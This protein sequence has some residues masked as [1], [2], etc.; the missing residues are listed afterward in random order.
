[1]HCPR[2]GQQQVSD[3]IK[4]CSRCGFQLG[5]VAELLAHG[6]FLPQLTELYKGKTG[7]FTRKNGVIAAILWFIF[8]VMM[9]PAF[10]AVADA[11]VPAAISA[12]FGVFSSLIML[13]ASIAFLPSSKRTFDLPL[14]EM[15]PHGAPV[16][17]QGNVGYGALPPQQSQPASS[18]IPPEGSWRADTA[19]LARPGSVTEGTTKLLKKDEE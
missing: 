12:V 9:M 18:Y 5:L 17:L 16:G 6:G 10:F 3:Q 1:M 14:A 15:P 2:C 11:E 8:F 4:F 19:D 13:I 7:W